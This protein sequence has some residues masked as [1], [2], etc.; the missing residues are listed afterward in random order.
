MARSNSSDID[1]GL[2]KGIE[3]RVPS[4]CTIEL[5]ASYA[6]DALGGVVNLSQGASKQPTEDNCCQL[7]R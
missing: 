1:G 5:D 4:G 6:G 2:K 3:Y 7:C